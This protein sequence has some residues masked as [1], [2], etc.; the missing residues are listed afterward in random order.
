[1]A[2][3]QVRRCSLTFL[4]IMKIQFKTTMRYHSVPTRMTVMKNSHNNKG[5]ESMERL[6]LSHIA[7]RSVKAFSHFG[8][9][10]VSASKS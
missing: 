6:Q 3:K 2:N 4:V 7:N 9:Q 5:G 8:K 1:M 10:S